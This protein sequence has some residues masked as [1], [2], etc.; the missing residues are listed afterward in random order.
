MKTTLA[1]LVCG[2]CGMF[3]LAQ[4]LTPVKASLDKLVSALKIK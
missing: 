1:I 4:T 3:M 2:I